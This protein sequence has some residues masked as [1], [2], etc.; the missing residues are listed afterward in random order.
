MSD[1]Q[2]SSALAVSQPNTFPT[3]AS[4]EQFQTD[5]QR[6]VLDTVAQ[7]RKCGLDGV[8]S[9]PQLVV[10]GD[11]SAGK[12]SVLEALTEIPF[13]R[14]DNLCTRFATEVTLRR[15]LVDQL[16]V[17]VIPDPSR[18]AA[19]QASIK[20]FNETLTD[21]EDLP[22]VMEKA[23]EVMGLSLTSS[24]S[25]VK[26]F[27][28][29]ILSIEIEGPKRP[30]LTLVDVPGLIQTETKGVTRQDREMVAEITDAYINQP[31]TICLAVI[32]ATHD[33]ANQPILTKVR[34]VDPTGERT[35]GIITKPDKLEANSGNEKMFLTLAQ[36]EDVFFKLGWH[37]V[38]NRKFDESDFSFF[39]RNAA[40]ATFFRTSNFKTLPSDSV[41]IDSL[42]TRLSL[43]LFE[44]IKKELPNLRR[45]LDQV[46]TDTASQLEALGEGRA[47][48]QE[49]R[50]YLTRLSM[51]CVDITKAAINGHYEGEHFHYTSDGAFS[52]D[53]LVSVRR[54]RAMVQCLNREFSDEVREQ[55]SKYQIMSAGQETQ[56]SKGF[57]DYD[58]P[59]PLSRHEALDWV[60]RVMVRS[61]GKEPYGNYNPS[62]IGEL[63]WEQTFKWQSLAERHVDRVYRACRT[64]LDI[65]LKEKCPEDIRIRLSEL[66]VADSL[67]ARHDRAYQEVRS[68]IDDNKDFPST[69]NHYYTDM[70]QDQQ[71]GRTKEALEQAVKAATTHTLSKGFSFDDNSTHIDLDAVVSQVQSKTNPDMLS[72][73]CEH[74][75]DC[76]L[77]MY[78]VSVILSPY[79]LTSHADN[80]Q[81]KMKTF[82]ENVT[83]QVVE[84]HLIRGLDKIF[85]PLQ[86]SEW[87]DA[88]VLKVAAESAP[89]R[90]RREFLVDRLEKLKNGQLIFREV[91]GS[92]N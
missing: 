18:S 73:S 43:L 25:S 6:H 7:I 88:A 28:R 32:S 37:V 59:T 22:D 46:T 66:Q 57:E 53:S 69:Y 12:S 40:E 34:D 35:L 85:S 70:I 2:D 82:V 8:L 56:T 71:S 68:L 21:L 48:S 78:K 75:L 63:F 33:Y 51:S 31:R 27:S 60:S 10:C 54:L 1:P 36:N 16:I 55:G 74:A 15:A 65:L 64:F 62:I 30:H 47:T 77:A 80:I 83:T 81:V 20:A 19:E 29:D 42:R 76:L 86:V 84:R 13:P 52:P 24:T 39:E 87:N 14:N 72:Y 67:K 4:L 92:M 23:K 49:C 11:Q 44:H 9:L 50:S 45:D 26:A 79:T 89:A 38:K 61:R 3:T 91:I 17:R 41:G 58:P 5:E 90:R